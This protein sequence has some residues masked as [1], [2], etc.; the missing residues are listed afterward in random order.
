[1]KLIKILQDR[2]TALI[3]AIGMILV[4]QTPKTIVV[5]NSLSP[6]E[7]WM[8]YFEGVTF[9]IFVEMAI[10]YFALNGR[11][12]HTLLAVGGMMLVNYQY[13]IEQIKQFNLLAIFIMGITPILVWLIT[14]EINTDKN[15]DKDA[16]KRI[17]M[18]KEE[19]RVQAIRLLDSGKTVREVAK[20]IGASK[21][22]IQ[23]WN[24]SA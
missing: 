11:R 23:R 6:S 20:T 17:Y 9:S 24:R 14:E 21:S 16:V 22:S 7:G 12:W 8:G 18:D 10:V 19:M 1:M 2:K 4:Y 15:G 13:Y 3:A 5:L